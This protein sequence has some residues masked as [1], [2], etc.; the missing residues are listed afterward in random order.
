M[1]GPGSEA[2][3]VLVVDPLSA[4]SVVDGAVVVETDSSSAGRVVDGTVVA[5]VGSSVISSR[6]AAAAA[7]AA[8]ASAMSS[9]ALGSRDRSQKKFGCQSQNR[10]PVCNFC[11]RWASPGGRCRRPGHRGGGR[12]GDRCDLACLFDLGQCFSSQENRRLGLALVCEDDH[13]LEPFFQTIAVEPQHLNGSIDVVKEVTGHG[14]VGQNP[15][16][17][18]RTH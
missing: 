10:H 2:S 3:V 16:A 11:G 5:V 14:A 8:V 6:A 12:R 17:N 4:G 15:N 7:R 1:I 9:A 13:F 18:D